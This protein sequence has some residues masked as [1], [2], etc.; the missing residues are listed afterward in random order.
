MNAP[1]QILPHLA[2]DD[3]QRLKASIID[4]GVEMPVIVDENGTIID[5]HHRAMIADSLGIEYPKE[6]RTGLSEAQKRLLAVDLNMARRQ[7]TDGQKLLLAEQIAPDIRAE[8]K[9]RQIAGL[10]Q[11]DRTPFGQICPNGGESARTP[12]TDD[13]VADKVGYSSTRTMRD[14]RKLLDQLRAEP[15]GETLIGYVESGDWDISDVRAELKS[16]AAKRRKPDP[17]PK[18]APEPTPLFNETKEAEMLKT[19]EPFQMDSGDAAHAILRLAGLETA[20]AEDTAA[21]LIQLDK[22]P[23]TFP[24]RMKDIAAKLGEISIQVSRLHRQRKAAA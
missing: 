5:G 17:V 13:V 19:P 2:Q 20:D 22:D 21:F 7:L 18:T 6:V 10:K 9:K 1:Y 4:R 8:A 14:H 11:G 12:R 15:D 16:R 3:L 24:E 23:A